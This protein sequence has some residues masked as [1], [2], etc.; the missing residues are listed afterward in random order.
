MAHFDTCCAL[1]NLANSRLSGKSRTSCCAVATAPARRPQLACVETARTGR[2]QTLGEGRRVLVA[3]TVKRQSCGCAALTANRRAPGRT[4][5]APSEVRTRLSARAGAQGRPARPEGRHGQPR[6]PSRPMLMAAGETRRWF[7]SSALVTTQFAM[8]PS[9]RPVR[10][11][12]DTALELW[13]EALRRPT[14]TP[15]PRCVSWRPSSIA[16]SRQQWLTLPR[17]SVGARGGRVHRQAR[18]GLRG[19]A[20]DLVLPAADAWRSMWAARS[21]LLRSCLVHSQDSPLELAL[22]ERTARR[23]TFSGVGHFDETETARLSGSVIANETCGLN[24]SV[25]RKQGLQFLVSGVMRDVADIDF[26][27]AILGRVGAAGLQFWSAQPRRTQA[28]QTR[29]ANVT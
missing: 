26:H 22:I 8:D 18:A 17:E 29:G 19:L 2:A 4:A 20:G 23:A 28:E 12:C 24:P 11:V 16:R 25:R 1:R 21:L 10:A 9:R 13:C 3:A 6:Q 7:R 5:R 27:A 15:A 14:E